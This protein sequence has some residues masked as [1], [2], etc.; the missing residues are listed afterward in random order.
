MNQVAMCKNCQ[1]GKPVFDSNQQLEAV[2]CHYHAPR[3]I[4]WA[5]YPYRSGE[6]YAVKWPLMPIEDFCGEFWPNRETV[7]NEL[8]T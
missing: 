5:D 6:G 2:E 4:Q 7:E 8:G 3:P 1:Y